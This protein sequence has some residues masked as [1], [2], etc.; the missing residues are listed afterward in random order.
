MSSPVSAS[1]LSANSSSS[2]PRKVIASDSSSGAEIPPAAQQWSATA[3][4]HRRWFHHGKPF[5]YESSNGQGEVALLYNHKIVMSDAQRDAGRFAT[6]I[7]QSKNGETQPA[8][9]GTIDW[10]TG[11]L[12]TDPIR[13]TGRQGDFMVEYKGEIDVRTNRVLFSSVWTNRITGLPDYR[14]SYPWCATQERKPRCTPAQSDLA[15]RRCI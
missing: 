13:I 6:T 3:L 2:S 5:H 8:L 15:D 1:S 14:C 11:S 4:K 12:V 9:T 10:E 7:G